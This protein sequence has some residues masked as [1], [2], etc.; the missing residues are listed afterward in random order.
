MS[1]DLVTRRRLLQAAAALAAW[2][3]ATR[4]DGLAEAERIARFDAAAARD[5]RFLP[6]KGV[7]DATGTREAAALHLAGR[8]PAEL[9]G[10]FYRNGPALFERGGRRYHHWFD[11]DGMVQQFTFTG[12]ASPTVA[13]RGRLVATD[14]LARERQA[15]RFVVGAFG[16]GIGMPADAPVQG[17]DTF[18]TANTNALEHAGRVL[19]MWEGGSAYAL[20]PADLATRGPVTWADGLAQVPFS[21]HP[22]VDVAGHLWNIGTSGRTLVLWHVDPQ[23]R[24]V[25]ARPTALPLPGAMV[26][27]MAVTAR[28]LVVPIPPLT[29]HLAQ[30]S[31]GATLEQ[32][33]RFHRDQPLRILVLDK[34]DPSRARLF[35]LPAQM[36]FHVGNAFERRDGRIELTYIGAD[37]ASFL[38]GGAAAM[39]RGEWGAVGG[40][41]STQRVVLDLATGRAKVE[42]FDDTAEF[43]RVDPRRVG[44]ATR[45][46]LTPAEWLP[47]RE[48][49]LFH[50]LQLR[51]LAGDRVRRFDYGAH[52]VVEEHLIV[53]KPGRSGELDAWLL[54]T[55]FDTRRKVT[56]LNLLDAQRIE[57]GPF[58]QAFLPYA[59]PYGF[60][61]NFTAA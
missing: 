32:A 48:G 25:S 35:E 1:T 30:L 3:F 53:P 6:L 56:V 19:A 20:D 31:R 42:A 47:G 12:G 51:D 57:D 10:R 13:H 28:H 33:M 44:E 43:P 24:L 29:L 40:R 4:A 37:D 23:G 34:N 41:S 55:T 26:H 59:L 39:M 16:T 45:W 8:W 36:V 50:G 2:P 14:K 15:G 52:M 54:G 18:N 58:A 7:T 27:D 49:G 22:K 38:T 5:A 61:G 17:P 60:H 46:L 21:A 11:G 9:R